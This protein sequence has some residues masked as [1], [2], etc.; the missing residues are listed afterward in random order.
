M[1]LRYYFKIKPPFNYSIQWNSVKSVAHSKDISLSLLR[2]SRVTNGQL[3]AFLRHW[4]VF[5]PF[6]Y[7]SKQTENQ[8]EKLILLL[9][10]GKI[11]TESPSGSI[12]RL[13]PI[14]NW[15]T[16]LLPHNNAFTSGASIWRKYFT[17]GTN[18]FPK[19]CV[20]C[21]YSSLRF[22]LGDSFRN[23]AISQGPNGFSQRQCFTYS[24]YLWGLRKKMINYKLM[25]TPK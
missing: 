12:W 2:Q 17:E 10:G 15:F 4:S 11:Y 3:I 18:T 25:C 6:R 24:Q 5:A 21:P 20:V 14:H 13:L 8:R 19:S 16:K 1:R 22:L 7:I 9:H 23:M